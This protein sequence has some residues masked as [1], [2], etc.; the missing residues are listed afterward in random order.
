MMYS[1]RTYGGPLTRSAKRYK[2][3]VSQSDHAKLLRLQRTVAALKPETKW[4]QLSTA[5]NNVVAATGQ[6]ALISGIAQ[7][8][9]E[10]TR[11]GDSIR[12][13]WLDVRCF[14]QQQPTTSGYVM[15]VDIVKDK[16][17]DQGFPVVSGAGGVLTNVDPTVSFQNRVLDERF[18]ILHTFYF[19]SNEWGFAGTGAGAQQNCRLKLDMP[20]T[21]SGTGATVGSASKNA[22]FAVFTTNDS[23]NVSDVDL[24]TE[25]SFTDV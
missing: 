1:K 7:G 4:F 14:M 9:T 15:R 3:R 22:L 21:F 10:N 19:H 11:V 13:G 24:S 12:A 25:L 17:N 23:S 6:I 8:I 16:Q 18:K 2:T 20:M 5:A